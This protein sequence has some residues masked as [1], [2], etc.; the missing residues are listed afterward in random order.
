MPRLQDYQ[1][2]FNTGEI[3]PRLAARLDFVKYRSALETCVNLIPLSEGGVMRRS[4]TR[5][6]AEAKSSSVKGRLKRF[7]FST[8]Q[9][10]VLELG[11]NIMRFYRHQAQITVADTDGAVS[12]GT[13]TGNITGWD[14]R[15]TGG[16]SISHDATNNRLSLVPGGTGA[17]DIGWAEQ[18]VVIGAG[19]TAVEHVL[20]FKVMGAPSD[21]VEFRVGTSSTGSQIIA[22]KIMEVGYHCVAFT[23]GATTFY[24]QFRNRGNFR[25]KTVQIEDVSLIDKAGVEIDTPYTEANL[26]TVGGPQS[27]D[28]LYLFHA[29]YPT[30]KLLRLGHT[31]WSL[32]EV[33]WQDGPYLDE[34]DTTTTL[35]PSAATGLGINLTLSSIVGVNGG[36]GWQ[37]TDIGRLVRYKETT[38]WGYAVIVSITSTTV[39][40]ADVRRDFEAT[41]TAVTT[42]RL[43]AW[44]GTTGY[45]QVATFFEQR[46]YEGATTDQPQTFWASQTADFENMQPDNGAGTV[47]ADDALSFTL[48]ADDVNAIR[49]MSAGESNLVIGTTGGEWV[50]KSTGEVITPLDITVRRQTKHGSAQVQPIRI[51]NAVLFVQ[52]AKR[53]VREFGLVEL[54][55]FHAPDMTRLA[56]HIT[57][58]GIVE[59]DYA[60]ERESIGWAVRGDGVLLSMTYRR[61]EDVVGW[62]RHIMGG[63]FREDVAFSQVWQ[64]DDSADTFVDETIDANDTGNADWTLFP[65][66]E[67]TGDYAAF[68]YTGTFSQLKFDY[69]NGTAGVG[70]VVSWEYW[71]GTAWTALSGVTDGTTGFTAAAADSLT[72]TWTMPTDWAKRILNTGKKL[73]YVRAKITTVYSTNPILDQGYV[74]KIGDAVVESVAVIPGD[75][76][77]GQ[78]QDSTDRDEVWLLVKRTI[79]GSTKRY[80]E[81]FERE[82]ETGHDQEDAYYL[83]SQITYDGTFAT[84]ITGF[85]HLE[86]ETIGLWADGSIHDDKTVASAQITLDSSAA[87]VQGGIRYKHKLKTLK[88]SAG[89]PAGTP[90]GKTKRIHGA[91]FVVL[92]AHTMKFGPDEDNLK[93]KDF[94]KIAD[95]MDLGAPL[96]TGEKFVEFEGDWGTDPRIY[97]ESDDPAPFTLLAIAPEIMLNP[98]K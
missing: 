62:A 87:V 10:Y 40:V 37:S 18:D 94:R 60:Q 28:V 26:P 32:V 82:Y 47:E 91:T 4:G 73:Y 80:I 17:T 72:V 63:Q 6:V 57:R 75:N 16:G 24:I 88:I 61:E 48:S 42:W 12:N 7:Q 39:A 97:L 86:G 35:L 8:T 13:F 56:E 50:P 52:R 29:S 49:W 70:G 64:V 11:T 77:S 25:N 85:D 34:N 71:N 96:F 41:P 43:G 19:F 92:N 90:V 22:D 95:P 5:H 78:T 23:P 69:L 44:S 45:P 89:N 84:T 38:N 36:L 53:K 51:G 3:S 27:A 66:S 9:A 79:N 31:T 68:G 21:R 55:V 15:S 54:D 58:G 1:P 2:N 20:K 93:D 30:H 46:L 14:N 65:A 74:Q 59:M 67:A 76:G 33:A 81:F 98:L 83:D